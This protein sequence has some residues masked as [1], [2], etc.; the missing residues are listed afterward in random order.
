MQIK[1]FLI[2][3][4]SLLIALGLGVG[5]GIFIF[6]RST[7]ILAKTNDLNSQATILEQKLTSLQQLGQTSEIQSQLALVAYPPDNAIAAVISQIKLLAQNNQVSIITLT[8]ASAEDPI[9]LTNYSNIELRA[10]GEY[11]SLKAFVEQMSKSLPI[12]NVEELRISAS[13]LVGYELTASVR[14]YWSPL[15]QTLPNIAQALD[16]LTEDEVNLLN[17]LSEFTQPTFVNLEPQLPEGG[18]TDP[19]ILR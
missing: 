9:T 7:P 16:N 10:S 18:R 15:P 8:A 19:F 3:V 13:A 5:G 6:S 17:Q 12:I 11:P 4:L 2:P 14:S 1:P